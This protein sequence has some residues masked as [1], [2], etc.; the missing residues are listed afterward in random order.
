M[1]LKCQIWP[2]NFYQCMVQSIK[3]MVRFHAPSAIILPNCVVV[4][5]TLRD[6]SIALAAFPRLGLCGRLLWNI[7]ATFTL[8]SKLKFRLS[9]LILDDWYLTQTASKGVM[10]IILMNYVARKG[11]DFLQILFL[12]ICLNE[13]CRFLQISKVLREG[14]LKI[15]KNRKIRR[16]MKKVFLKKFPEFFN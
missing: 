2:Q 10:Q 11:T 14:Y 5:S 16:K 6:I 1:L 13:G 9:N 8:L 4:A 15:L 12:K 7:Y 3:I